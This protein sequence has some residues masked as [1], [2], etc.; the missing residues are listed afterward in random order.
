MC[1]PGHRMPARLELFA[2]HSALLEIDVVHQV[3]KE[4]SYGKDKPDSETTDGRSADRAD[5]R[6]GYV[7]SHVGR[8][9][10][11]CGS[12]RC[13]PRVRRG[14]ECDSEAAGRGYGGRCRYRAG[15]AGHPDRQNS[16]VIQ[17][18]GSGCRCGEPGSH[19]QPGDLCMVRPAGYTSKDG[20]RG[21]HGYPDIRKCLE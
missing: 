17:C 14:D 13:R 8:E 6:F 7:H 3:A 9:F 10:A 2:G 12:G 4:R 15:R 16:P 19:R 11:A 18:A 5:G 21:Q 20:S 1:R